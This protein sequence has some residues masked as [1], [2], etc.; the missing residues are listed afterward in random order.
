MDK[1]SKLLD[2]ELTMAQG[3]VDRRV[4]RYGHLLPIGA[5]PRDECA[6]CVAS[7]HTGV[8]DQRSG[9]YIVCKVC[10]D[11]GVIDALSIEYYGTPEVK[12]NAQAQGKNRRAENSDE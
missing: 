8:F 1:K 4:G 6:W 10:G 11:K 7:G 12:P 5:K 3:P 2:V 9:R